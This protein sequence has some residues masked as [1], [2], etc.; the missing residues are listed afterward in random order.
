M[1]PEQKE[2]L[3]ATD[4]DWL[5]AQLKAAT[6]DY[7]SADANLAEI[8]DASTEM[9]RG[10]FAQLTPRTGIALG[11][12]TVVLG[13]PLGGGS[14]VQGRG[15]AAE[16]R[17]TVGVL[18]RPGRRADAGGGRHGP[19]GAYWPSRRGR[20]IRA[21][22]L[23]REALALSGSDAAIASGCGLD[24]PARPIARQALGWLTA[25]AE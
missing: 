1:T 14:L 11:A 2:V 24:F 17:R 20:R 15:M 22:A 16:W 12:T 13:G 8:A 21:E 9:P 19:S 10:P 3:G 7:E 5:Q 4:F 18:V 25:P 23:F 6:G